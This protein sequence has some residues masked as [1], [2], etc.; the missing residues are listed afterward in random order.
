MNRV[1]LLGRLTNEPRIASTSNG[2]Q[3]ASFT[4]A[5]NRDYK[6][7][8]G[9]Y[10]ADFINC[11]AFRNTADFIGKYIK[12]GNRIAIEGQVHTRNY[13]KDNK[14][15]YIT[16]IMVEKITPLEKRDTTE[17]VQAPQNIKTEYDIQNSD[18]KVEDTD[19]LF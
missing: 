19:L 12:K 15:V 1:I 10:E 16:E 9:Q 13:E 7:K 17:K 4:I 3:T 11:I 6:N 14:K 8:N 5:V 2:I 18:V